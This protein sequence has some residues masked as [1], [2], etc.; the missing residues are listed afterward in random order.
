MAF[1]SL[2]VNV[3]FIIITSDQ[4]SELAN[5]EYIT[6]TYERKFI[7]LVIIL[8][9]EHIIFLIKFALEVLIPDQPSW[10]YIFFLKLS[11]GL[12]P[13]SRSRRNLE[14]ANIMKAELL[15]PE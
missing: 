3:L 4:I 13:I 9:A 1:S 10:V 7:D 2:I 6:D 5:Y 11:Y 8:V 12:S 14:K 15:N